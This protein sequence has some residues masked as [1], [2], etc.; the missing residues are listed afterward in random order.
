MRFPIDHFD[1][2]FRQHLRFRKVTHKEYAD[3]MGMLKESVEGM[4]DGSLRPTEKVLK[5]MDATLIREVNEFIDW[6]R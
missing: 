1:I 2:W 4:A 6:R 5:D 3:Q